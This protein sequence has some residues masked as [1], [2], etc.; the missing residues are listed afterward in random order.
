MP[1][2]QVHLRANA[3]AWGA[4][5]HDLDCVH[6][7]CPAT[8]V[9]HHGSSVCAGVRVY[10]PSSI[11]VCTVCPVSDEQHVFKRN[12]ACPKHFGMN[13]GLGRGGKGLRPGGGGGSSPRKEG[14]G[15]LGK[16]HG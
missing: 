6:D 7:I 12:I 2:V 14:V 5:R 16:G 9:T 8:V 1:S 11:M 13:W 10:H 4:A 15:G 3:E